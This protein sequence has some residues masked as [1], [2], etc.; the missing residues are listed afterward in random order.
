MFHEVYGEELMYET[1]QEKS[2]EERWAIAQLQA[3]GLTDPQR[4]TLAATTN[5]VVTE[6][7][8]PWNA[9]HKHIPMIAYVFS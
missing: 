9:I 4:V 8:V 7:E 5:T 2:M 6:L 3:G 1:L